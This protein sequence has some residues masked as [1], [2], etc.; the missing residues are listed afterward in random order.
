MELAQP[1][2]NA[3]SMLFSCRERRRG[4]GA[5]VDERRIYSD[6]SWVGKSPIF[7]AE[8]RTLIQVASLTAGATGVH[9]M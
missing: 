2:G 7:H 3:C 4:P 5:I 8:F 6:V 9:A 1:V